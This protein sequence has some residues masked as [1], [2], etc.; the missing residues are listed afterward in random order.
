MAVDADTTD[1]VDDADD[2]GLRLNI[3]KFSSSSVS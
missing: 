1:A 2:A 3:T